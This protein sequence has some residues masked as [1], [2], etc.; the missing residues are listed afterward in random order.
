MAPEVYKKRGYRTQ[1]L[2]SWM[3]L[4]SFDATVW[5]STSLHTMIYSTLM[6]LK[7]RTWQRQ[8]SIS[9]FRLEVTYFCILIYFF[10]G[11]ENH[12]QTWQRVST[13]D[14]R[15]KW[16]VSCRVDPVRIC[17]LDFVRGFVGIS[18]GGWSQLCRSLEVF[19]D[20]HGHDRSWV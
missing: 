12:P 15:S 18:S 4:L 16:R 20:H 2:I 14:I 9:H 17:G 11:E 1:G 19:A 8:Q 10:G 5:R 7:K 6:C 13:N 3:S